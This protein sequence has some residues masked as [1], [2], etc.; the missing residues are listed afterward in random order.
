MAMIFLLGFISKYKDSRKLKNMMILI[1]PTIAIL[2][3]VLAYNFFARSWV[4]AGAFQTVLLIILSYLFLER[5]K[6]HPAY[7]IVSS[8]IYGSVIL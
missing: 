3:A 5:W 6:V 8:L 2:L 4:H 7:V 1:K